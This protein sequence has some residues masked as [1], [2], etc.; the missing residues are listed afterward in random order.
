MSSKDN[1]IVTAMVYFFVRKGERQ[2]SIKRQTRSF[3]D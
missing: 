3:V 1:M 2:E